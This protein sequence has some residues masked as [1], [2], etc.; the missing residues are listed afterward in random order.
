[1][2][3]K[4]RSRRGQEDTNFVTRRSLTVKTVKMGC[5]VG[6]IEGI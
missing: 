6:L 4:N 1:M 3:G 5:T 2:R